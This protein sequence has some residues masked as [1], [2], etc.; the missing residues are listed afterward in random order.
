MNDTETF[1]AKQIERIED[2]LWFHGILLLINTVV[3]SLILWRLW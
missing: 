2:H 1:F 3:V